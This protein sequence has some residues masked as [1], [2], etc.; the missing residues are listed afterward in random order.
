MSF[1]SLFEDCFHWVCIIQSKL[2]VLMY[3]FSDMANYLANILNNNIVLVFLWINLPWDNAELGHLHGLRGRSHKTA[4]I[5]D[6]SVELQVWGSQGHC[7]F[8]PTGSTLGGCP[9]LPLNLTFA[10]ITPRINES[11]IITVLLQ[12]KEEMLT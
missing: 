7:H 9:I 3:F 12:S 1:I 6:T 8:K 11:V 2:I 4:F 5:G 10:S